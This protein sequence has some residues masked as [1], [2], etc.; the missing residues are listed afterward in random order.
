[1]PVWQHGACFIS[2]PSIAAVHRSELADVHNLPDR[3]L[4]S[5]PFHRPLPTF[6]PCFMQLFWLI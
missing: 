5:Y 2:L 1:M 6:S 4:L 3:K